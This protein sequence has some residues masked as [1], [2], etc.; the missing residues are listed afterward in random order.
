[1]GGRGINCVHS[2]TSRDYCALTARRNCRWKASGPY[3]ATEDPHLGLGMEVVGPG[4]QRRPVTRVGWQALPAEGCHVAHGWR[5][6]S[7]PPG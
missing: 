1:M 3:W 6:A 2:P 7:L 4:L 5:A